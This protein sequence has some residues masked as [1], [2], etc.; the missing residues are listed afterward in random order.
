MTEDNKIQKVNRVTYIDSAKG[1]GIIFVVAAHLLGVLVLSDPK[2]LMEPI[3]K[4]LCSVTIAFFFIASGMTM[5]ITNEHAKDFKLIIKKKM[6]TIMYPYFTF[7]IIYLVY[8]IFAVYV[9]HNKDYSSKDIVECIIDTVTLRGSSVLWFLSALFLGAIFYGFVFRKVGRF[10]CLIINIILFM[11]T[12]FMSLILVKYSF[13]KNYLWYFAGDIITTLFRIF[14][15]AFFLN[16]GYELQL[17]INKLKINKILEVIIGIILI[18]INFIL[19]NK[20]TIDFAKNWFVYDSSIL[21][22]TPL[23]CSICMVTGGIG[24]VLIVK[25][26]LDC[27]LLQ[28]LGAK[29]I[30]IMVTHIDLKVL[31][32]ALSISYSLVA[33]VSHAKVYVLYG[34]MIGLIILF[35]LIWIYL[36]DKPLK[37]L[38]KKPQ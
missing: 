14:T 32:Y 3:W 27:K 11:I 31:P 23:V 1:L 29:S 34:T 28:Y 20:A 12:M 7:S 33:R 21:I 38:I 24:L 35:E 8:K 22:L 15:T 26:I 4:Y 2:P 25:N 18:S 30:I 10:R 19:A 9:T 17:L 13:Y 5:A 6:N 36:F 37:F 16:L